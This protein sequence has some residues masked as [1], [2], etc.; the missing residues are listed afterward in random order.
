[1]S[2]ANL[3]IGAMVGWMI[4]LA[5]GYIIILPLLRFCLDGSF[6]ELFNPLKVR[7]HRLYAR[8]F[9]GC[10]QKKIVRHGNLRSAVDSAIEFEKLLLGA[11]QPSAFEQAIEYGL[12]DLL[13]VVRRRKDFLIGKYPACDDFALGRFRELVDFATVEAETA[14]RNE[15]RRI[16]GRDPKQAFVTGN[17]AAIEF[18]EETLLD[19]IF[20]PEALK[21]FVHQ[22]R[23][24]AGPS[25]DQ[26]GGNDTVHGFSS[27]LRA[28]VVS[29]SP[30]INPREGSFNFAGGA[31]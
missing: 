22:Q 11:I 10:F 9:P 7:F 24:H 4:G 5:V 23:E 30:I 29:G 16:L 27:L 17:P 13:E 19:L 28:R 8:C 25:G 1:M 3:L 18:I 14:C 15:V 20:A 6:M 31:A 12:H 21:D 2:G 26:S